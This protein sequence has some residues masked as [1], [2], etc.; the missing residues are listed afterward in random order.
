MGESNSDRDHA[1]VPFGSIFTNFEYSIQGYRLFLDQ[2]H[3]PL[4]DFH[5][6]D[7]SARINQI[8]D[9]LAQQDRENLTEGIRTLAEGLQ[10]HAN[11]ETAS[12]GET[13]ESSRPAFSTTIELSSSSSYRAFVKIV[14]LLMRTH[15]TGADAQLERL[16]RSVII[17][18]VGQFEVLIADVAHQFLER[19]PGALDTEEK[20]LSLSDLQKFGSVDAAFDYL[21]ERKIDK[22]LA[23]SVEDWAKFFDERKI[24]LR[25][26]A[27]DWDSFKEI[28]QRRHI[29]VHADGRISRRYLQSVSPTLVEKYFGDPSIGRPTRL[30]RG[31]VEK[32][33]DHFEILDT[34]L[35]CTAWVMLDKQSLPQFEAML[36]NWIYDRLLEGRWEMALAMAREGEGS[37]K[38]SHATRTVCRL[39][40]WLCIKQIGRFDEVKEDVAN[41]DDSAL[42]QRFRVVRLAILEREEE[43]FDLLETSEGGGLDHEAWHEWPVFNEIRNNPRFGELA[44]RFAP[45]AGGAD[46][47]T[48][49]DESVDA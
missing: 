23:Q 40:A 31:Y 2:L 26:M 33:L 20:V 41:F 30:D 39:N 29:I 36:L 47:S 6:E 48:D 35:C 9:N 24:K 10:S 3:G 8:R 45:N 16:Y 15:R 42:E 13:D 27:W 1:D 46:D 18:L 19:A 14:N 22:L 28:I 32:A 38:L 37:E 25:R 11:R 17:G 34:L 44:E 5:D 12:E 49:R 4:E 21:I 43:L 7:L